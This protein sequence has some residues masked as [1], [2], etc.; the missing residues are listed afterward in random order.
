L[1]DNDLLE[2]VILTT[3][4]VQRLLLDIICAGGSAKQSAHMLKPLALHALE[5]IVESETID[6]MS[7]S[8][9][10][11]RLSLV[12]SFLKCEPRFD[13][14]T[15]TTTISKLLLLDDSNDFSY[16]QGL[17]RMWTMYIEFLEDQI[18]RIVVADEGD[19]DMEADENSSEPSSEPSS[20]KTLGYI[21]LLF[22]A[23]KR[24]LRLQASGDDVEEFEKF[25]RSTVRRILGFFMA[26]AFFDC[27]TLSES[28][29]PKSQKK[30]ARKQSLDN[31]GMHPVVAAGLRVKE[32]AVTQSGDPSKCPYA[33]RVILSSRF[34]SLL[35]DSESMAVSLKSEAGSVDHRQGKDVRVFE[36]L[37]DL[38][39]GWALLEECG[40]QRLASSDEV[41]SV[42]SE[43]KEDVSSACRTVKQM[44]E[45][46]NGLLQCHR[47]RNSCINTMPQF[48]SMW[49]L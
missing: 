32:R 43:S 15:K 17:V 45:K 33:V 27:S 13:G 34:F 42:D 20:Y 30:K 11:R 6:G 2:N 41:D 24:I 48:P 21:D 49:P 16:S 14:R 25:R 10:D 8:V 12:K 1:V 38:I 7:D 31:S 9:L 39:R 18:L 19:V 22:G 40:A 37:S 36:T 4:V 26:S 29:K 44:Q 28:K 46:A 35:A 47:R 3:N 5:A 23:A